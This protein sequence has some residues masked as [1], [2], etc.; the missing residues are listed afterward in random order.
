MQNTEQERQSWLKLTIIFL[1]I[2]AYGFLNVIGSENELNL[3]LDNEGMLNMLKILQAVSV[4]LVF[5][6]P[7][8]LF[9]TLWTNKKIHYLGVTTRPAFATIILAGI[10]MIVAMP[11]INWLAEVNQN[12]HLPDAFSGIEI[13]MKNSEEKASQ[14]TEA[15]TKGTSISTLVLNLF[16][17]AFMAAVSEELF[18]RGM[19]QKVL[20]ECFKNKHIAIWIGAAL[21]SAFHMQFYGFIPRMLMGA[22]LGYLFLWSGSLYASIVAHFVNNGMAVLLVWLSNKGSI[23]VD[24]DKVGTNE[25]ELI[26]VAI[27]LVLVVASL[28]FICKLELK[29]KQK[30]LIE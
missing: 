11:L 2:L 17:V 20:I 18:F 7:A 4:V 27:S 26:F 29:K 30:Q 8:I 5:I 16:V 24:I 22:F 15:F 1:Y 23:S 19:L 21:F 14:L 10:G 6:I 13:W 9:A 3:N 12:M 28:F 25:N